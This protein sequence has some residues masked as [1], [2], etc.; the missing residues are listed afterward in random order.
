MVGVVKT[1][2]D[3][4]DANCAMISVWKQICLD[5][6]ATCQLPNIKIETS[7]NSLRILTQ[8]LYT[9][10][11]TCE[12]RDFPSS[13]VIIKRCHNGHRWMTREGITEKFTF[14]DQMMQ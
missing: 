11:G 3:D 12:M 8:T 9:L 1:L 13:E 6:K 5:D 10:S 4:V 14:V 2:T 7:E